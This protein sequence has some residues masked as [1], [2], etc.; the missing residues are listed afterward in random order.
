MNDANKQALLS[1]LRSILI[2]IGSALAAHGV[3]GTDAVN[4]IVGAVMVAI[5]I[6]WGIVDKY[7]SESKT[8]AR[9]VVAVNAGMSAASAGTS[10]LVAAPEAKEIIKEFS[11]PTTK[12]TDP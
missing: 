1:A 4:E 5:P 7:L 3:I 12:G 6:V 11:P 8:K 10:D 9:E 2:V